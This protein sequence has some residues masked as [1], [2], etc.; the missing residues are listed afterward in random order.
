MPWS[1][2]DRASR[3]PDDWPRRRA[4][5]LKRDGRTCYICQGPATQ[6][7]HVQRGDNH[8]DGNLAAICVP[9]HKT[10]TQAEAL[11]AKPSRRRA[12]TPHPGLIDG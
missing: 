6:V 1:T 5:I 9:C 10:K 8:D 12:T 2:S 3:L 4:R 11:A 7:D